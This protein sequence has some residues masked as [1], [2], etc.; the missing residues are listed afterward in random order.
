MTTLSPTT[1]AA[2]R[3]T[4]PQPLAFVA[5]AP[6]AS[7]PATSTLSQSM[8]ADSGDFSSTTRPASRPVID[9][10]AQKPG[11]DPYAQKPGY[12]PYAQKPGYDP[13]SA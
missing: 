1:V 4:R 11:Y 3:Y 6:V 8:L 12:D 7:R 10:Y 9:P 2:P 13:Y 5:P